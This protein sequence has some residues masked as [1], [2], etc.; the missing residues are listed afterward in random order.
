MPLSQKI[1]SRR[2]SGKGILCF[3]LSLI[4]YLYSFGK[5]KVASTF[6]VHC[7]EILDWEG[8]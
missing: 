4:N 7:R 8:D 2:R 5:K 6:R 3:I 1:S